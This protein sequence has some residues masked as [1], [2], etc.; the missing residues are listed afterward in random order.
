MVDLNSI[1]PFLTTTVSFLFFL[2]IVEQYKRKRKFH[3]LIWAIALFLF[4]ITAGA[5]ALALA[6]GEWNPII[7]K[8]YYVLA[9]IQVTFMGG[10]VL[11]LFADRK[12][13]TQQNSWVWLLIF[14]LVWGL[15]GLLFLPRHSVF[16][17]FVAI[18]I[19]TIATALIYKLL[20]LKGFKYLWE[21]RIDGWFV[22]N[23]FMAVSFVAFFSMVYF[24]VVSPLNLEILKTGREV[25]GLPWQRDPSDL[26]EPRAVVRLFSPLHTVPGAIALIGGGFYSY[27]RWQVQLKKQNGHFQWTQGLFNVYIAL[28][29]LVLGQGAFLS[30]FGYGTLYV[31]EIIAVT[32]MY[33]GFLESDKISKTK[34]IEIFR[35]ALPRIRSLSSS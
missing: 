6:I 21:E 34:L 22:A 25:S 29:A 35:I 2:S 30:G 17:I 5:E 9:A 3:Q 27:I 19:L 33:F 12:V 20:P 31:S 14:S 23:M 24:A 13:I 4:L 26:S 16:G 32:L 10:G 18:S 7:Y 11:Y 8:A 15:F 1:Y 28:G